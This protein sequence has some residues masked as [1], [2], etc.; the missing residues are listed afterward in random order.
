MA[1][2]F[3]RLN[4][5]VRPQFEEAEIKAL[6]TKTLKQICDEWRII[7]EKGTKKPTLIQKLLKHKN[8]VDPQW[9]WD[10]DDVDLLLPE[11]SKA[12]L[13]HYDREELEDIA[14]AFEIE[15]DDLGRR[16]L[17]NTILNH[18]RN[19]FN[20]RDED[21]DNDLADAEDPEYDTDHEPGDHESVNN[22]PPAKKHKVKSK[23]KPAKKQQEAP[24]W[25]E[26]SPSPVP[27]FLDDVSVAMDNGD[28]DHKDPDDSDDSDHDDD[29]T[30]RGSDGFDPT[31]DEED[32]PENDDRRNRNRRKRRNGRIN[33]RSM[34]DFITGISQY[35]HL[36]KIDIKISGDA[37]ENL[38]NK[39]ADLENYQRITK[40]EEEKLFEYLTTKGL[41]GNARA[42]YRNK[43]RLHSDEVNTYFKLVLFLFKHFD[44]DNYADSAYKQL[45]AKRQSND[46]ILKYWFDYQ[47][48]VTDYQY[49][50]RTIKTYNGEENTVIFRKY[51]NSLNNV[52]SY[53]H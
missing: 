29:A 10:L 18:P 21:Y 1:T 44:A 31:E 25:P 4:L 43:C 38:P 14:N 40:C 5:A 46:S 47:A 2:I 27:P 28:V 19:Q 37:N 41:T 7:Y 3:E 9:I 35:K 36:S 33:G 26:Q 24:V 13:K 32:E 22:H 8:N 34:N 30:D 6:K 12:E 42:R 50:I 17:I 53:V 16:E 23:A 49:V 39:I 20:Y 48:A 51:I 52:S 15:Y 45:L 11:Y